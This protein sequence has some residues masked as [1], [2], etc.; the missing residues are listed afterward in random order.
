MLSYDDENEDSLPID[1]KLAAFNDYSLTPD[2][3]DTF[4]DNP[5]TDEQKLTQ[6][7]INERNAPTL[8]SYQTDAIQNLRELLELQVIWP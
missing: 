1:A 6:A 8:L 5:A 4:D 2:V 3:A 7:W